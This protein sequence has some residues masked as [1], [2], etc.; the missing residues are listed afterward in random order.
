MGVYK[1][2]SIQNSVYGHKIQEELGSGHKSANSII[3]P[4]GDCES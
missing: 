3:P 4:S 1:C 2:R